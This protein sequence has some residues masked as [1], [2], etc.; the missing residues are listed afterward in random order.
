MAIYLNT[1]KPY[2]SYKELVNSR[3]F[4][5]KSNIIEE[6][7]E[8]ISTNDKYVCITRPRRFGKSSIINMLGAY[9]SKAVDS[10]DIFNELKIS[11]NRKYKENLNKYNVIKIDFSDLPDESFEYSEYMNRIRNN[12]EKDLLKFYPNIPFD[13]TSSLSDKFNSTEAKFIFIFDEWDFIFNRGLFEEYHNNFLEFLRLLLKDKPYVAL[14]YMTGILPIKKH[15]SG[16]A[17][18]MFEEFT[19]LKDRKFEE[20]FGFTEEEVR[21]LCI[22]NKNMK[23]QELER[24]YNGYMTAT[25]L[26][27]YNPRSVVLALSNNY[28]QSYWTNTGAMDEV[29]EYLKY[30]ILEV[31]DDVIK[32]VNG[33]EVEIEID[34]EYRAGQGQPRTRE[35]IYS[36]MIVLG[37]LSYY[38]GLVKIP[39]N[40]LMKE[41]KKALVDESFGEVSKIVKSSETML[42]ATV[43][44][45]NETVIKILHEVHNSEIP[46]LKYNDENSLSCVITL[47]YLYARNTYRIEREE[48]SGKGFVDFSFHPRRNRDIPFIIELK[49]DESVE[50][51]LN[52]IKEKEYALKFKKE[53][54]DRDVLAVAI[55]YNSKTKEHSCKI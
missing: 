17:L 33:E 1:S 50:V 40:E 8:R 37:F 22:K 44:G 4:V 30:N 26:K 32:M 34:E 10:S 19:F 20:Y 9:Y 24:W 53:Y 25:G 5:D 21:D 54:K 48:W 31:R 12:I 13:K 52:Q 23:Y 47:A 18:N 39:N 15:S 51:A 45:D 27:I 46:I 11:K 41:F 16:S 2:E 38:E 28:C 49:K 55:C 6:L 3:Y 42:K 35:E 29:L 7:N 14:A 43:K 36:A